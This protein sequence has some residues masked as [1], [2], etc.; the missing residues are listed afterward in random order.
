MVRDEF[1]TETVA[2]LYL[3]Q[4]HPDRALAIFERLLARNP[5]N[6]ALVEGFRQSRAQLEKRVTEAKMAEEKKL[7]VLQEMLAS[8]EGRQPVPAKSA[9]SGERAGTPASVPESGGDK[10]DLLRSMLQRLEDSKAD[11]R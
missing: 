2:R 3:D 6:E 10:L 11:R 8:L 4:G 1:E 5:G 7:R 9:V